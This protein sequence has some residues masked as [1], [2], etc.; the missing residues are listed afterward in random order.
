MCLLGNYEHNLYNFLNN[1]NI[2]LLHPVLSSPFKSGISNLLLSICYL[3]V[4]NIFN[5]F[6]FGE[7]T[8]VS[9][10]FP[11]KMRSL[12]HLQFWVQVLHYQV[13]R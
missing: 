8:L 10:S 1:G 5:D 9:Q 13:C 2:T 4:W 7:K 3:F 12:L 6:N 11:C